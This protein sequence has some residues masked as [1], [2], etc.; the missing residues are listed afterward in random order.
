MCLPFD[1]PSQPP[2]CERNNWMPP[3]LFLCNILRKK[4]VIKLIFGMQINIEVSYQLILT[5]LASKFPTRWYYKYWWAWSSILKLP[6]V[7]SFAIRLQYLKKE[8]RDGAHFLHANKHKSFYKLALS[9]LKEVARHVQSTQN[10]KL[11]MFLQYIRKKVSQLF[12]CSI[13]MQNI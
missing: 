3:L 5:V 11:V 9:F 1:E 10:R 4:W 7:T 8:V 13:V 12:L 2:N 6:K